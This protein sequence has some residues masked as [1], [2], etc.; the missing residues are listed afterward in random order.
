MGQRLLLGL[1]ALFLLGEVAACQDKEAEEPRVSADG[2][3]LLRHR[4]QF[5]ATAN[6]F[7]IAKNGKAF[8]PFWPVGV[9]F[10]MALPGHSAGEHLA[11]RAQVGRWLATAAEIGANAVQVSTVQAPAFYQELRLWNLHHQ[12]QP[13]FLL[14]GAWILEPLE[15]VELEGTGDYLHPLVR[16]WNRDE[17]DK[18]VDVIHG[19]RTIAEPSP[20]QPL[21]Y[22]RAFGNFD[23]DVSPWLLGYVV[24]RELEPQTVA[25]TLAKHP[26]PKL[27][28]YAGTYI[29]A[30]KGNAIDAMLAELMDYLASLEQTRYQQ[31]HPIG[32]ENA[33]KLDPL[34]HP[35]E[36]APP[37]SDADAYTVDPRTVA[38]TAKFTAGLF[39]TY[40]V[41][42]YGPEFLM[43]QPDYA[44]IA[45]GDGA[46]PFLGYLKQLRAAH[47]DF[48]FLV[49]S[50]VPS[51]LGCGHFSPQGLHFGGHD[52]WMQ[53]WA[54]LKIARAA[55]QAGSNGLFLSGIIDEWFRRAAVSAA[56]APPPAQ[57]HLW[58]NAINPAQHFGLVALRPGS[59]EDFHAI[60][61]KPGS[62][63]QG[64]VPL[65]SKGLAPAAPL[66]DGYDDM[67]HLQSIAVDSDA[68][69]LHLLI[70]VKSLD[71][72]GNGK[73][74]WDRVDYAI[75]LDTVDPQRGDSR[76]DPAG[77]VQVERRVEFQVVIRSDADVKLLVDRPYD[78]FGLSYKVRESWQKYRSVANDAGEFNLVRLLS[79]DRSLWLKPA[80]AAAPADQMELAPRL[81]HEVGRLDTGPEELRTHSSFWYDRE[82]GTLELRIPWALLNFA[83]PSSH[84]VVDDTGS[85]PTQVSLSES[86]TVGVA[87]VA[88]SASTEGPQHLLA[89]ALPPPLAV[90]SDPGQPKQWLVPHS[91]AA[92]YRWKPWQGQPPLHE[93]RK[94]SFYV[95]REHLRSVLPASAQ[96]AP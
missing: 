54:D 3:P 12:D 27:A 58:F 88:Y 72:D 41:A 64:K 73:V 86:P 96:V 16:Q 14:Q 36:P 43:Y 28:T 15:K 44:A 8:A 84:L 82:Q 40:P 80:T 47:Q 55:V 21:N 93:V 92:S 60:D 74:D 39:V 70:K 2:A 1:L 26:D 45:D 59:P 13:L 90:P 9:T 76:L 78:L 62:D 25:V 30:N 46:N 68:G 75:A 81:V 6:G 61:G 65:L 42:P 57:Q 31:Q 32:V 79:N 69:Y 34:V 5:R 10:G 66:G 56:L 52:E 87:V 95:L 37:L 89:D 29:A 71:P 19:K 53:G 24:G 83:D 22:G 77:Q 4:Y 91:A 17:V 33:V 20:Q 23:A 48:A 11:S 94:K 63:W 18:V 50:G 49:G 51:S 85:H 38:A 35:T 67:R 7:E